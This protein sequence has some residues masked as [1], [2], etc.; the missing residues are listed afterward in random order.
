MLIVA[1]SI[2]II[3]PESQTK[4]LA[5]IDG[6]Q[7][8]EMVFAVVLVAT[9]LIGQVRD[10]RERIGEMELING[11]VEEV[12]GLREEEL[13]RLRPVN[14]YAVHAWRTEVSE[15]VV[16]TVFAFV[17]DGVHIH[18]LKGIG[19]G[20]LPVAKPAVNRPYIEPSGRIMVLLEAIFLVGIFGTGEVAVLVNL[21]KTLGKERQCNRGKKQR[22]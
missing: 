3:E 20:R 22:Y 12:I 1:A 21:V 2:D 18:V 13:L 5:G 19:L 10:R 6:K 17:E 7:S 11:C 8:L 9:F 16:F 4:P 15:R 14:V